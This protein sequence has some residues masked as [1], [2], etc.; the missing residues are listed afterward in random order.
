MRRA[1]EAEIVTLA[2]VGADFTIG[3]DRHEPKSGS[4]FDAFRNISSLN[5]TIAEF[6]G[7]LITGVRDRAFGLGV[8]LI[9]RS[10]IAIVAA[11]ARSALDEVKLGIAPMF[12]MEQI[13]EYCR[14]N[15]H[16]IFI[17]TGREFGA[18]EALQI[19]LV[20]RVVGPNDLDGTVGNSS[21][22]AFA[23][24]SRRSRLQALSACRWQNAA[25]GPLGLRAC[26]THAI[27]HGDT[28]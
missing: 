12:V 4:P 23:R 17:L 6:P 27:C 3:R 10:D 25:R 7:V 1:E 14:R 2:G 26:G 20:S 16:S 18:G 13:L 28:E 19:G 21:H 8:G 9:L 22:A 24:P 5:K 11:D 15:A